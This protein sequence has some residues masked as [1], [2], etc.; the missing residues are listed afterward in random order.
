MQPA[1]MQRAALLGNRALPGWLI[2][3]LNPSSYQLP[4]LPG[5]FPSGKT[6]Q[7]LA[8]CF[9]NFECFGHF[10]IGINAVFLE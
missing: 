3:S 8:V 10:L 2:T 7:T 1:H 6:S 5:G 9:M 4:W